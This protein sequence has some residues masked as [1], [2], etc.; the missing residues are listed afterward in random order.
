M[1]QSTSIEFQDKYFKM[2][3]VRNDTTANCN[4][5]KDIANV[6]RQ[7][8]EDLVKLEKEL[9]KKNKQ[10]SQYDRVVQLTKKE[11]KKL[12]NKNKI[13]QET[14]QKTATGKRNKNHNNNNNK[15]NNIEQTS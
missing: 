15:N 13:L 10:V 3:K 12:T 8:Q 9:S 11:C 5:K 4:L 1:K 14:F 6:A 7:L 2:I